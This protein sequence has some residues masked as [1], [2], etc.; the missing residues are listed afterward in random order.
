[1]TRDEIL[2]KLSIKK[3]RDD[4]RMMYVFH[5]FVLQFPNTRSKA[6][7]E[8]PTKNEETIDGN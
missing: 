5:N 3:R 4:I 1:M 7:S 8:H 6:R 2:M